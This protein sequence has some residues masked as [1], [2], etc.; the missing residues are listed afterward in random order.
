MGLKPRRSFAEGSCRSLKHPPPF[1][2]DKPIMSGKPPGHG[3]RPSFA[4][5][6]G[7]QAFICGHC[8]RTVHRLCCLCC[9][10]CHPKEFPDGR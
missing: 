7:Q 2:L 8:D 3:A 10:T 9:P 6:G 1:V 5:S 4:S